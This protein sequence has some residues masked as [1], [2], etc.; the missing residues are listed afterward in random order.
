MKS[1]TR[2][3][4]MAMT[5][6]GVLSA[7]AAVAQQAGNRPATPPPNEMAGPTP[8]RDFTENANAAALKA[9]LAAQAAAD[10][11]QAA[12]GYRPQS[13]QN[14]VQIQTP[15]F[16]D[17]L[18][19]RDNMPASFATVPAKKPRK[20]LVFARARGYGHSVIPLAAYLTT[21]LG[22]KTGAWQTTVTYDLKDFTAANLAN[23]DALQL[24]ST[25]GTFLDDPADA[26]GTAARK[27]ALL[28]YVRSGHGLIM[29]HAAG[30]SYHGFGT[31]SLW[32]EYSK[33]TGG[34]F[35]F[36]WQLPQEITVKVDDPKSPLNAAYGAMPYT[37]HDE[38]YTFQQDEYNNRRN[39]HV[40][41]SVDYS[42]MSEEDKMEEPD[43]NRRTDGDYVVSWIRREGQGRVYYNTLGHSEHTLSTPTYQKQL[44]AGIQYALGDLAADDSPSEK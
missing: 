32:P 20:V 28:D 14:G 17:T 5:A 34:F 15:Y 9:G 42:K 21:Q 11:Q 40:L 2:I 35:K 3:A 30:D 16:Q 6:V 37:V 44:V 1:N 7:G 23:Y 39:F 22:N 13:V 43:S 8:P 24:D 41:L 10:A 33:M 4:L 19:V 27:Q 18:A 26:A 31:G 25:T 38:I 29:T 12:M 36:H